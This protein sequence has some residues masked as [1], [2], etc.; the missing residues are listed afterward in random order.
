M[1]PKY[2]TPPIAVP[3]SFKEA[4]PSPGGPAEAWKPAAPG[5]VAARSAWWEIYGDPQLNALEEQVR[6]SNQTVLGAAANFRISRGLAVQAR[7]GLFPTATASASV[8]RGRSSQTFT[9]SSA[10][11]AA[12]GSGA[13]SA[14]GGT[15]SGTGGSIVNQYDLPVD[16][17]YTI[18]VWGRIRNAY[19]AS[20]FTA[21]ASAADLAAATLSIQSEL[22]DDYFELRSVDD[23][24]RIFA[25]TVASYRSTLVLTQTLYRSGID[26]EED[27]A[28]A[29]S[30]LDTVIAEATDVDVTRAQ[31]EHAIAV[32]IGK[33]PSEFSVPVASFKPVWAAIPSGVPSELLQRR[34]DI[35]AAERLVAAANAQVGVARTA[36]YPSLTL[37]ADAG[38]ETSKLSK[39]FEWPSRFWSVG[40]Q[41]GG[42]VFDVGGLRG[43]NEQAQA[44]YDAAV[45]TYRQTVLAAFQAVEDNLAALRILAIESA[46]RHTAVVSS[47]HYLDLTLTRYKA[48]IDSSLN[49][50]TAQT[51]VLTNRQAE[52]QVQLRQVQASIALVVALGGGWDSSQIPEKKDIVA[53]QPK[54]SP[55]SEAPGATQ[56]AI[57]PANPPAASP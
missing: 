37:G 46:Q 52:I 40:P 27:V 1:A 24:R 21:Q 32:L 31:F 22:A 51:A 29:Q 4:S 19:A 20:T 28:T 38:F 45:A 17:S 11:G 53:R 9:S 57:A 14:S 25:D 48:G 33:A 8:A 35:A 49:V 26:S 55:A 43:V 7:A 18:D 6:L 2:Q 23:E 15:V 47:Q 30:Q 10:S 44:Q 12:S 56:G 3:A 5:E 41:I 50:A 54:W 13:G 16:A 34:P 39:W 36:Y 42:T